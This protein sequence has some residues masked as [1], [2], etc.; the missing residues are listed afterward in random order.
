[1]P[2]RTAAALP[3]KGWSPA[4]TTRWRNGQEVTEQPAGI[5]HTPG[6]S[7]FTFPLAVARWKKDD[8][9]FWRYAFVTHDEGRTEA[10]AIMARHRLKVGK[11]SCSRKSC[12]AWTCTIRPAK[13]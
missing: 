8:D 11:E 12:A 1:V 4:Q 6:E 5:R 2:E 7:Q 9:M 3:E 13:A 10:E